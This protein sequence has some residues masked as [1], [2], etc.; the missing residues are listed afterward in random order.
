MIPSYDIG[1]QIRL[2]NHEGTNPDESDRAAFTTV[3]G[4]VTDPTTVS[5]TIKKADGSDLTYNYPDQGAG[6]GVLTREEAGRFY[7]DLALDA[8]GLWH[9][10]LSGTGTVATS[11]SGAFYVRQSPT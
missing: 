6:D 4:T 11:E 7:V 3:A 1:D 5:L 2:G 9:W 8:A 10:S